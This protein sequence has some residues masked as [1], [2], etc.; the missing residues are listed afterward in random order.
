MSAGQVVAVGDSIGD[1]LAQYR[2]Y[3]SSL[4]LM[5]K[6]LKA[7]ND[8]MKVR[9]VCVCV[10]VCVCV[11]VPVASMAVRPV[12]LLDAGVCTTSVVVA[13]PL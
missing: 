12:S 13:V 5:M 2:K 11:R 9:R 1:L 8:D 3:T 10:C 4:V 7:H 6:A